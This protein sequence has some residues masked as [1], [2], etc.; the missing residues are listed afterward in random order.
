MGDL[1]LVLFNGI[2]STESRALLGLYL[3]IVLAL[4]IV[5]MLGAFA[6]IDARQRR[7]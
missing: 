3:A 6:W 2:Y 4:I 5:P 1:L 7:K